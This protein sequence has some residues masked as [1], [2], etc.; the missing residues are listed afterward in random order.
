MQILYIGYWSAFDGLSQS[1][2]YPNLKDLAQRENVEKVHY[3]SIERQH[4]LNPPRQRPSQHNGEAS[5]G[6]D[7]KAIAQQTDSPLRSDDS[8]K[9]EYR[10]S[11]KGLGGKQE[12]SNTFNIHPKV[13]HYPVQS[14]RGLP[15]LLTKWIDFRRVKK[16]V[17]EICR[18]H[19]IELVICRTSLAGYFGVYARRRCSLPLVVESFEPHGD[20]MVESG[21]WKQHGLKYRF[22]KKLEK[23][24]LEYAIVVSPVSRNHRK[25]LIANGANPAR[26]LEVPCY[27]FPGVFRFDETSRKQIRNTLGIADTTTVGIYTGK[28]GDIYYDEEAFKVFAEAEKF[29]ND[30]F[31]IVLSPE[32][33]S[34]VRKR[35]AA[36]RSGIVPMPDSKA[37]VHINFVKHEEVP[38][39]LSAAD[40]AFSTIRPTPAR[41]FCSPV[42]NGE[43]WAAGLPILLPNGVGDDSEIITN[44]RAGALLD[45][46]N[47]K[48]GFET[49]NELI[50]KADLRARM[51]AIASKHR[52]FERQVDVY[53][54]VFQMLG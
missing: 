14:P 18:T 39:Y 29:F 50:A 15:H 34:S 53:D 32:E 35:L 43:Y 33:P 23:Q 6:A 3:I 54:R 4:P 22:Q 11:S 9:S 16:K 21:A 47:P 49:I 38:A 36:A 24:I 37:P 42:K 26:V 17:R 10:T 25:Q 20:Y 30:F 52:N 28:F 45:I 7:S 12:P 51:A 46:A 44:E 41:K 5:A 13:Y 40:F 8:D 2:I 19:K 31:L 1:T 27:V 48:P